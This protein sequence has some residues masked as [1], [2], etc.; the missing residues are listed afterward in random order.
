MDQVR[1]ARFLKV[2]Y[3]F[4][5]FSIIETTLI[6][7]AG[8]HSIHSNQE[9]KSHN[10]IYG[11][12]R[13]SCIHDEHGNLIYQEDSNGPDSEKPL[14]VQPGKE[15]NELID[16]TYSELEAEAHELN[17]N[18]IT[19]TIFNKEVEINSS[20]DLTQFD[21]KTISALSGTNGAYCNQC[22][23]D[24][25]SANQ[26]ENIRNGFEVTR[27]IQS[28]QQKYEELL[29]HPTVRRGEPFGKIP[30]KTRKGVTHK[31]MGQGNIIILLILK[32]LHL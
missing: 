11:G 16:I 1:S 20:I 7:I 25:E 17:Q 24:I 29:Q 27:S 10:F 19:S 31:P 26:I 13:M 15:T 21:N 5:F 28:T 6:L 23:H 22:D 12:C 14:I 3:A 30:S 32:H 2:S 9:T 8:R 18:P 4:S